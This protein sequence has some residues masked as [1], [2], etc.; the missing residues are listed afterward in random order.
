VELLL[1][2]SLDVELVEAL[3]CLLR[4]DLLDSRQEGVRFVEA[5]QEAHG[6]VDESWLVL[7]EVEQL[8][9]LLHVVEPRVETTCG[10]P[11]LLGP[12]VG[13][14][15]QLD[16][17]HQ[18]LHRRC[19]RQF[20]L[21]GKVEVLKVNYHHVDEGVDQLALLHIHVLV[22][23]TLVVV[24]PL[25][26]LINRKALALDLHLVEDTFGELTCDIDN[27][28]AAIATAAATLG[29]QLYQDREERIAHGRAEIKLSIR[30]HTE[31]ER[32]LLGQLCLN[33][34]QVLVVALGNGAL[35]GGTAIGVGEQFSLVHE[36]VIHK[37]LEVGGTKNAIPIVHNMSTVH[38]LTDQIFQVIPWDF[39]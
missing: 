27:C 11:A 18:I 29:L 17:L 14:P 38:D 20:T 34:L 5:I 26:D 24:H 8:K 9:A 7:P 37:V 13:Q 3:S 6:L 36:L 2:I 30:M 19:H 33:V 15:V 12:L 16:L 31:S 39:T 4:A 23:S 1:D 28:H 25:S 21:E 35:E 32:C 22:R 10:H